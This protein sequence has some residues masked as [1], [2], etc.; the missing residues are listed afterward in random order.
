MVEGVLVGGMLLQPS[1]RRRRLPDNR[2][3]QQAR[4][5]S[6]PLS[7]LGTFQMTVSGSNLL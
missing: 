5:V 1:Y 6:S 2:T 4:V 3:S 7:A